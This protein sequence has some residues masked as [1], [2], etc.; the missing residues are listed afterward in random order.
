LGGHRAALLGRHRPPA[1]TTD[2][3]DPP[4]RLHRQR[5]RY[6]PP[7]RPY[8]TG[9][10]RL[11]P[12]SGEALSGGRDRRPCLA[13]RSG[14]NP[15]LARVHAAAATTSRSSARALSRPRGERPEGQA[16]PVPEVALTEPYSV[17]DVV[18]ASAKNR[19]VA[20]V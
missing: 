9:P 13:L 16:M 20:R 2:L 17:D 1:R 12:S 6:R 18:D 4:R 14:G 8:P 10:H 15:G 11:P 7:R 5:P 3:P 19:S